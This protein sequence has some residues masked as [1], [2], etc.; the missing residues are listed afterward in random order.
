VFKVFRQSAQA[1]SISTFRMLNTNNTS[2]G[3]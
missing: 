3:P 1:L 2:F